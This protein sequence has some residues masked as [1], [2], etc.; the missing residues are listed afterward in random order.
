MDVQGVSARECRYDM[1]YY[2]NNSDTIMALPSL[3]NFKH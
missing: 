3:G 2:I 1:A